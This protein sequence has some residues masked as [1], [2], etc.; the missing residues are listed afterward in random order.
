MI[1]SRIG[2]DVE[3]LRKEEN[4]NRDKLRVRDHDSRSDQGPRLLGSRQRNELRVP[5]VGK[6]G[7]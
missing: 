4:K 5:V 3:G 6:L 1:I 7:W 2:I